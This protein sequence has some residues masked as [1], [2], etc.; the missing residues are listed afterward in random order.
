VHRRSRQ[1]SRFLPASEWRCPLKSPPTR[2]RRRAS[3]QPAKVAPFA[4]GQA[5]LSAEIAAGNFSQ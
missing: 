4:G 3:A 2:R 1:K 5:A